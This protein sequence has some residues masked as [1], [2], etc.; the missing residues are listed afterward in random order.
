VV[1]FVIHNS[2]GDTHVERLSK[3]ELQKR[4]DERYYG[5]VRCMDA[6]ATTDTNYWGESILIIKGSIA[7]PAARETVVQ[8][9]LP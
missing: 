5:N 9:Q 2:E 3:D 6:I 7:V 1:Y 8:H 4:L